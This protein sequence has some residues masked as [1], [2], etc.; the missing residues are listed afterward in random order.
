MRGGQ[1][2]QEEVALVVK[3]VLNAKLVIGLTEFDEC[4]LPT[5]CLD[6]MEPPVAHTVPTSQH[7]INHKTLQ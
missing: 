1:E 5:D 2:G 6:R 3:Q 4:V 7:R